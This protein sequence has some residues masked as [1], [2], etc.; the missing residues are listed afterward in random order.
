MPDI[1]H[2]IE[3]MKIDEQLCEGFLVSASPISLKQ[4]KQFNSQSKNKIA[5]EN[6]ML[7]DNDAFHM[8]YDDLE[9]FSSFYNYRIANELQIEYLMKSYSALFPWGDSLADVKV[10]DDWM[11]LD[12][13]SSP[14]TEN[15]LRCLF[16]FTWTLSEFQARGE[17]EKRMYDN[18]NIEGSKVIKSGGAEFWPW[19]NYG[20]ESAFCLPSSRVPS[21]TLGGGLAVGRDTA[22]ISELKNDYF[23]T[24]GN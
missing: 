1:Y 11:S 7:E 20:Q 10:I 22:H 12:T 24:F 13:E 19:Q 17:C 14:K 15:G 6:E 4:V 3:A 18:V 21:S 2:S 5:V 23:R 8:T 16:F 9:N